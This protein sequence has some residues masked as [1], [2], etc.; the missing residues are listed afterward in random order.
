MKG[1]FQ[2]SREIFDNEVWT[3]IVK[4]RLFFYILGNAVFAKDG[5]D[6]AGIHLERGQYLR[7]MRN[8]QQDLSYKEGRGNAI[9]SYPLTTIQRKIKSLVNEERITV[10]S[11]EYGT[12]FTVSNYAE[13]QGFERYNKEPVEQLRNSYGTA[14]EQ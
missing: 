14:T 13:Y 11:T 12:L 3:D 6:H 1:A 7:S 8:L 9:K 2:I 10:K 4:F 5:I